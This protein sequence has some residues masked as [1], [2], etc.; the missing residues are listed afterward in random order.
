MAC[1]PQKCSAAAVVDLTADDLAELTG[2]FVDLTVEEEI[3]AEIDLTTNINELEA[4]TPPPQTQ[5][6]PIP[7]GFD[8]IHSHNL[9]GR[10]YKPGDGVELYDD[11]GDATHYKRGDPDCFRIIYIIRNRRTGKVCY[12]GYMLSCT[13]QEA[14]VRTF[15]PRREKTL[16]LR[17]E[18]CIMAPTIEDLE[19][20][21][22]EQCL[23]TLYP[24]NVSGPKKIIF[25]NELFPTHSHFE[26]RRFVSTYC[27]TK[28]ELRKAAH[29]VVRT[30]F[31]MALS[32]SGT[33]IVKGRCERLNQKEADIPFRAL[34]A[35][36]RKNFRPDTPGVVPGPKKRN[37]AEFSEEKTYTI[38]SVCTGA[39]GCLASATQAGLKPVF[40]LDKCHVARRTIHLNFDKYKIK[41]PDM[42]AFDFC[43]SSEQGFEYTE[44]LE[45]S[46]PCPMWSP[47]K[48]SAHSDPAVDDN[49]RSC[50]F[51]TGDLLMKCRPRIA[52]FEQ[53]SGLVTHYPEVFESF[54]NQIT[55]ANYSVCWE[56]PDLA[57]YEALSHRRR[58][59]VI[60]SCPGEL[61]PTFPKPTVG[62]GPGMKRF[63]N[64]CDAVRE[65]KRTPAPDGLD[66]LA[67]ATRPRPERSHD[68][69]RLLLSTPT[70][71]G[72]IEAHMNGKRAY[73]LFESTLLCSFPS[74]HRFAGNSGEVKRQQ[75]NA[76]PACFGRILFAHIIKRLRNTDRE[77]ALWNP[78]DEVIALDD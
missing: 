44:V 63:S 72:I 68:G 22:L 2:D 26:D 58:L 28:G 53:T 76:V 14:K 67:G 23:V 73:N 7:E 54:I 46:W 4:A 38:G 31:A 60:A 11:D 75:G 49:N 10:T 16:S 78:E 17:N 3:E 57:Y 32:K 15:L 19:S 50:I 71:G 40:A 43:T 47:A 25:T 52:T 55:S 37:H 30:K 6:D 8:S 36:L 65:A 5:Q 20:G 34:D 13:N 66:R 35:N 29:L 33:S 74:Y 12:R 69:R 51:G 21:D 18:Y 48:T 64:I 27:E 61:L 59:I 70:T 9:R 1:R 41:V 77:L 56:V 62:T 45:V 42:D 24:G 39:G